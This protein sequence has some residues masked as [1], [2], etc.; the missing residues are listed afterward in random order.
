MRKRYYLLRLVLLFAAI[1]FS[2]SLYAQQP[3]VHKIPYPEGPAASLDT[4]FY[5]PTTPMP[6]DQAFVLKI[7][8]KGDPKI[9]YFAIN[10]VDRN[11]RIH[12]TR[13]DYRIAVREMEPDPAKRSAFKKSY[14]WENFRESKLGNVYPEVKSY[15]KGANT[16]VYLHVT[17]LSPNRQYQII[18][19][20]DDNSSLKTLQSI[21]EYIFNTV[22][23]PPPQNTLDDINLKLSLMKSKNKAKG[24]IFA[25]PLNAEDAIDLL[26]NDTLTFL[27]DIHPRTSGM[28]AKLISLHLP[29][30]FREDDNYLYRRRYRLL[31]K[32]DQTN[33]PFTFND[34]GNMKPNQ[35]LDTVPDEN[36]VE[37]ALR[38]F[39]GTPDQLYD[40]GRKP[41]DFHSNGK[42][43]LFLA[44]YEELYGIKSKQNVAVEL[45]S[46]NEIGDL[47]EKNSGKDVDFKVNPGIPGADYFKINRNVIA[48]YKDLKDIKTKLAGTVNYAKD[49]VLLI[50]QLWMRL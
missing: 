5:T 23:F 29:K 17:P 44:C 18:L 34:L 3:G 21:G 33:M 27:K 15:N 11:G 20:S 4:I 36:P 7:T 26:A 48:S 28:L 19:L 8:L 49:S 37:L 30:N 10:P 2:W 22:A 13:R 45:V 14:T 25:N 31:F 46:F 12:W 32:S 47:E 42:Y 41:I 38:D 9:R 35:Y 6:F 43:K 24:T 39:I 50:K 16:D 40:I 1:T